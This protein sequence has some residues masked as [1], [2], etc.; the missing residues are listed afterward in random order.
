MKNKIVD[1]GEYI[2]KIKYND[3]SGE[4]NVEVY[5]EIGDIIESINISDDDEEEE[6]DNFGN[7]YSLN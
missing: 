2:V 7:D 6:E 5:D 1:L 3:F 4:L